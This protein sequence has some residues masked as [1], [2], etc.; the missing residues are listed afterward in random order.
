MPV[1][2]PEPSR[3]EALEPRLGRGLPSRV[4][5]S[6]P[7]RRVMDPEHFQVDQFVEGDEFFVR[8][9]LPGIDA[10][11]DFD[12]TVSGDTL[13]IRAE[14]RQERQPEVILQP[15]IRY[16]SLSRTI[17]LPVGTRTEDATAFYHN[18]VLTVRLPIQRAKAAVTR[19]YDIIDPRVVDAETGGESEQSMTKETQ[20][21]E[22]SS[23]H[24]VA[25]S[26]LVEI[27]ESARQAILQNVEALRKD[28]A[29]QAFRR[30]IRTRY[31]GHFRR[32]EELERQRDSEE[33][34]P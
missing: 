31:A 17:P 29:W 10:S 2:P 23:A 9:N 20:A 21:T 24:A 16:G 12:I 5:V 7:F 11:K 26:G 13:W 28:K 19:P 3:G 18:G 8:A 6:E 32:L 34:E 15:E 22:Q 33:A 4:A 30:D 27:D 25:G 1:I 14:R